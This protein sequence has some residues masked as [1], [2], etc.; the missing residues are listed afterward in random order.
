M[1][2]F[3]VKYETKSEKKNNFKFIVTSGS[4]REKSGMWDFCGVIKFW[5]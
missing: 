1:K 2:C 4:N 3:D 5:W